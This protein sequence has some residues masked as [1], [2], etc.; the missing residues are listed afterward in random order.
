[1]GFHDEEPGEQAQTGRI[2]PQVNEE[3]GYEDHYPQGW[4]DNSKSPARAAETR[5]RIAW[6]FTWAG[7]IKQRANAPTGARAGARTPA[8]A[9]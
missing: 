2:I 5:A 4:G 6:R 7:G 1:V 3:Y 9:G 8:G